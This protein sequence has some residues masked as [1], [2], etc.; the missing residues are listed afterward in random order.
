MDLKDLINR[1]FETA[2]DE[3][4]RNV[5][6][7]KTGW[8]VDNEVKAAIK[9]EARKILQEPDMQDALRDRMLHWI[10]HA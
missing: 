4:V 3:V 1:S 10:K 5:I 7:K 6:E 9:E 2:L 8:G